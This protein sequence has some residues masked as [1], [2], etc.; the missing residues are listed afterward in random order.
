MKNKSYRFKSLRNKLSLKHLVFLEIILVLILFSIAVLIR[1]KYVLTMNHPPLVTDAY[2][3]DVMTKQFLEKGFLGYLSN[4]P[5]AYITPGYPLFLAAIYS[6]FGYQSGSPLLQVRIIQAIL[7]SL[8]CII[9]YFMGKRLKNKT[10]GFIAGF[11][12][13]LYPPFAW[14]NTLI[15]T[16]T[17]YNFFFLGYLYLQT[18]ILENKSRMQSFLC[19]IVFALAVLIR[20][21][22]FPLLIIP[23]IL[24]YF[25]DSR[26]DKRLVNLFLYAFGGMVLVMSPWWIRNIVVMNKFILLATQTG[27]PFIAGCFPYF[28]NMDNTR[29]NVSNQLLEGIRIIAEGF[30]TKP[31]LYLKWFTIGKFNCLFSYPWYYAPAEF[32]FLRSIWLIHYVALVL[33]W[34]G[35][36]YTLVRN[37]LR[38]IGLYVIFLTALQFLFIP[39]ARYAYSIFPLLMILTGYLVDYLLLHSVEKT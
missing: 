34:L 5:N 37:R 26:H 1:L 19:G 36:L 30:R 3:Y 32:T 29:Y 27:N 6:F 15:L 14:S 8:T 28:E 13:A 7:G 11:L 33:G 22:I 39:D 38:L 23:F 4:K 12:Y 35:V 21:L 20:P 16:E 18:R 24:S 2:N 25:F 31:I 17:I 9:V 10:V